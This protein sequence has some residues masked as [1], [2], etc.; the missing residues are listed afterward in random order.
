LLPAV[1]CLSRGPV[2]S[3]QRLGILN[4]ESQISLYF[5]LLDSQLQDET[6]GIQ[7][8]QSQ[9]SRGAI[10]ARNKNELKRKREAE[11]DAILK[12]ASAILD[13]AINGDDLKVFAEFVASEH[14]GLRNECV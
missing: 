1:K 11:E 7:R 10:T 13:K 8:N 4:I 5:Q 6:K 12:K 2:I 3:Q 14:R 9:S